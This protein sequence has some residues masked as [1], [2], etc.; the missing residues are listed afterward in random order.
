MSG[1]SQ[2]RGLARA[3][4][5]STGLRVQTPN[6]KGNLVLFSI[7]RRRGGISDLIAV[8]IG[9]SLTG[10]ARRPTAPTVMAL[11]KPGESFAV[12]QQ[13]DITCRTYASAQTG[14]QSPGQAAAQSG[15]TGAAVGTGLGAASGALLGSVSGHMGAGAA[16]GAGAGLLG[17]SL[18]GAASGQHA[19]SSVQNQYNASYTQCMLAN[20]EMIAPPAAPAVV[21]TAPPPAVVYAPAPVYVAPP[22]AAY[23][24]VP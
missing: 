5:R 2:V 16:I 17:G 3:P 11:P 8:A 9:L 12:F 15:M 24:V 13:H 20:G 10:C 4:E 21:Y 1:L 22:P 18:M 7:L 23:V 6:P 14:G 19:A